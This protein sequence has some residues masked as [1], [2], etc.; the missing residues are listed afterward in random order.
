QRRIQALAE[1]K[2]GLRKK[3][4]DK[5]ADQPVSDQ[6][7]AD[8]QRI[9]KRLAEEARS[10]REA[11]EKGLPYDLDKQLSQ[12]LNKL[13]DALDRAANDVQRLSKKSDLK[14]EDL[15]KALDSAFSQLEQS[16]LEFEREAMEP[17]E[18]LERVFPLIADQARFTELVM[19][20]KEL[21]QRAAALK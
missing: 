16:D 17:L 12:H 15:A 19:R 20:Q 1:E 10:I 21:A 13:A 2:Q 18:H 4:K 3:L 8:L 14:S 7:R 5:P 6:D 9:E 11:A